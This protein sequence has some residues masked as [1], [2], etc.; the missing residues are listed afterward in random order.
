MVTQPVPTL[1]L[2][3][4]ASLAEVRSVA[5]LAEVRSAA[6]LR[7]SAVL[8]AERQVAQ[9]ERGQRQGLAA[10]AV[11]AASWSKLPISVLRP[12]CLRAFPRRSAHVGAL[13]DRPCGER[14]QRA[15]PPLKKKRS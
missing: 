14:G 13:R 9:V 6:A 15:L 7:P 8:A 5:S 1:A 11:A 12:A 4:V 10:C 2:L 3:A